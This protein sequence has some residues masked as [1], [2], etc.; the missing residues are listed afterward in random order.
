MIL[1]GRIIKGMVR[2]INEM[3]IIIFLSIIDDKNG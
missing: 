3:E 1:S 2:E